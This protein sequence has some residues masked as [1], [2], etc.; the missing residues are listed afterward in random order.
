MVGVK[1]KEM[2]RKPLRHPHILPHFTYRYSKMT[3]LVGMKKGIP[4]KE[5]HRTIFHKNGNNWEDNHI[6]G[7]EG[8]S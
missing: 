6:E 2:V 8:V 3:L 1:F 5:R 4:R 7:D